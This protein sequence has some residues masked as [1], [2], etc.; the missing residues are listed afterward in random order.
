MILTVQR[1]FIMEIVLKK[2]YYLF[3]FLEIDPEP[4]S[5]LLIRHETGEGWVFLQEG[6]LTSGLRRL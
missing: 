5:S 6:T 3:T 4:P 1:G 2:Q